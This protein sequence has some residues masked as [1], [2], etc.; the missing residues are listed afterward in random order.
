MINGA[1]E[2]DSPQQKK[3]TN[4]PA[5]AASHKRPRSRL[6]GP[7]EMPEQE[8]QR[9]LF[10]LNHRGLTSESSRNP[11]LC[12]P[13]YTDIHIVTFSYTIDTKR[14]SNNVNTEE[15]IQNSIR[16]VEQRS[17]TLLAQNTIHC[18]GLRSL[19][20]I[21]GV[22]DS[23][24]KPKAAEIALN[25]RRD[26]NF[27]LPVTR[28][29][30]RYHSDLGI[31]GFSAW[32]YDEISS[33]GQCFPTKN[34]TDT[35]T[36]VQGKLSVYLNP[37][38][39]DAIEISLGQRE[40]VEDAVRYEMMQLMRNGALDN[41]ID[42]LEHT[43]YLSP[44]V[45][46]GKDYSDATD[47]SSYSDNNTVSGLTVTQS[48]LIIS[49]CVA[50]IGVAGLILAFR[51]LFRKDD[52]LYM[53][54]PK[55]SIQE[56]GDESMI[57]MWSKRGIRRNVEPVLVSNR[58]FEQEDAGDA[59]FSLGLEDDLVQRHARESW[60]EVTGPVDVDDLSEIPVDPNS[61]ASLPTTM[62]RA[63]IAKKIPISSRKI[64]ANMNNAA[65]DSIVEDDEGSQACVQLIAGSPRSLN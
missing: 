35:C 57:F 9:Q 49:F 27:M 65:L 12:S 5:M 64:P 6:R 23:Q 47:A 25:S 55:R 36:V 63:R 31:I 39:P 48:I 7:D 50:V 60:R 20:G 30:T 16:Q 22:Y 43:R 15:T 17:N 44:M 59:S 40:S 14:N 32:P 4:D 46:L 28:S 21:P 53:Q 42:N 18:D 41:N 51:V 37:N 1:I 19:A 10:N 13:I 33:K 8:Q 58:I 38:K 52:D 24:S 26:R 11:I 45:V 56:A 2:K 3:S 34:E 29:L 54:S 62:R 61:L